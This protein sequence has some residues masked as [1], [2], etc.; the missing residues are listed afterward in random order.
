[1]KATYLDSHYTE[2]ENEIIGGDYSH[3]LQLLKVCFR[4]Y[5][6]LSMDNLTAMVNNEAHHIVMITQLCT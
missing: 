1:M 6:F 5:V 2:G 4:R 3:L